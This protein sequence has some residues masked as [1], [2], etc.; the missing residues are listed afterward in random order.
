[1]VE[2]S[3]LERL[4]LSLLASSS[5][6]LVSVSR[7]DCSTTGVGDLRDLEIRVEMVSWYR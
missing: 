6:L 3:F 4:A 2:S 7:S 1:M 5:K